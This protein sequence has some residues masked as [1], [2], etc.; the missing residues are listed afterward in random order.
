MC[1]ARASAACSS[2]GALCPE[3]RSW[4]KGLTSALLAPHP[5]PKVNEHE[6]FGSLS[7]C[8]SVGLCP[9]EISVSV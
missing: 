6:R 2:A 9:S 4:I 7:L 5:M 3:S 8:R 1:R